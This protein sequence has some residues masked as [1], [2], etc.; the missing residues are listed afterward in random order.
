MPIVRAL[1]L[2]SSHVEQGDM[3]G[4]IRHLKKP[5]TCPFILDSRGPVD[6][7]YGVFLK[8]PDPAD[9]MEHIRAARRQGFS[10]A[11][12]NVVEAASARGCAF[13]I[14]DGDADVDPSLPTH[15]W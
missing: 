1:E 3:Q 9:L 4:L 10:L 13:L 14:L 11:F 8:L 5:D 12:C 6:D 2:S 15:R 7:P